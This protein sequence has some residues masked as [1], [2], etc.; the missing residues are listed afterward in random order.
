LEWNNGMERV[1][2]LPGK[3]DKAGKEGRKVIMKRD[4]RGE[5]RELWLE[6]ARE[7]GEGEAGV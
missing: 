7:R 6:P 4:L 3:D 1:E 2:T 5:N